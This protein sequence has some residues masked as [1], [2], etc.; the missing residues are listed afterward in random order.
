MDW[1][2]Y[3]QHKFIS[4]GSGD[5]N[6]WKSK[7]KAL[8]DLTSGKGL[9]PGLQTAGFSLCPHMAEREGGFFG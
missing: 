8:A 7:V 1:V 9:L 3:V 5:I 2:A 4:H 6:S